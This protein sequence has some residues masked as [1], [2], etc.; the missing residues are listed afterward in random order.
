MVFT[1]ET[2]FQEPR[3]VNAI[4][5]RTMQKYQDK[6]NWKRYLDPHESLSPTFQ[7][8]FGVT[9]QTV[10]GSMID[11]HA[12]KPLRQRRGVRKGVGS[13]GTF[14]DAYQI[15]ED[16][17][18]LLLE[19][20]NKF[21]ATQS[22]SALN[23]IIE[24]ITDDYRDALLAPM[25]AIDKMLGEAR[26]LGFFNVQ[27]LGTDAEQ[28]VLPV[29]KVTASKEAVGSC[30]S[31]YRNL[32]ESQSDIGNEFA[33]C[34]M[35][36]KTFYDKVVN[37]SEFKNTFTMK[38]GSFEVGPTNLI[39]VAKVNEMLVGAGIDVPIE[40]V[41]ERVTLADGKTYKAFADNAMCLLPEG[42]LGK[43]EFY[44]SSKWAQNV[45][46]H[47]RSQAEGGMILLD[48]YVTSEGNFMEY[49]MNAALNLAMPHKM[50]VV[51]LAASAE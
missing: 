7:T 39:S 13:I 31:F 9:A 11:P 45:P 16:R 17:L 36:S 14:G 2:L 46:G 34:Q 35:T 25:H 15:S 50:C 32:L 3:I 4:I 38:F 10:V 42:K 6:I 29:Q 22:Q 1:L 8:Y 18:D 23:E 26:S 12:R 51:D 5:D 24:F 37:S 27:L 47:T 49:Q 40:I 19:L 30:I 48:S 33:V 41:K 21:N 28:V 43:V 44:K 20:I